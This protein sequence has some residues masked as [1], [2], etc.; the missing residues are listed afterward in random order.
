MPVGDGVILTIVTVR[1]ATGVVVPVSTICTFASTSAGALLTLRPM[2]K[3]HAMRSAIEA[4]EIGQRLH[5][6][7]EEFN[8]KGQT[9]A[10]FTNKIIRDKQQKFMVMKTKNNNGWVVI[11]VE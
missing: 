2:G 6:T 3:K 9:P 11:R 8:W 1:F 5:I 7:R 10:R 4:L